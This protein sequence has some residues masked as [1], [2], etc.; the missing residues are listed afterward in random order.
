MLKELLNG[1]SGEVRGS[2][3]WEGK[4]NWRSFEKKCKVF[5]NEEKSFLER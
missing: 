2:K 5:E 4:K 3:C 1:W